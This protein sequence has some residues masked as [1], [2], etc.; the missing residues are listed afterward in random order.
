MN[1]PRAP[2]DVLGVGVSVHLQSVLPYRCCEE[3]GILASGKLHFLTAWVGTAFGEAKRGDS[4][5]VD[6]ECQEKSTN[7]GR[8]HLSIRRLSKFLSR[9]RRRIGMLLI[10]LGVSV[11]RS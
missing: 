4:R 9:F 5:S 10:Q 1:R 2:Q 3:A 8:V 7:D 11:R 6:Y